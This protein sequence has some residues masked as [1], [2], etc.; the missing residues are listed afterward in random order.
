[1]TTTR[2]LTVKEAAERLGVS[3]GLVYALVRTGKI[4]HERHGTGRGTIRITEEA[5]EEYRRAALVAPPALDGLPLRH[6]T[7]T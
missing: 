1:M 4:R 7:L 3:P 5:L 6:I 2:P